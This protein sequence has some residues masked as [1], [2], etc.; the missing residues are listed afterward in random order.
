MHLT[1]CR[2]LTCASPST[3]LPAVLDDSGVSATAQLRLLLVQRFSLAATVS[4]LPAS[5]TPDLGGTPEAAAAAVAAAAAAVAGNAT[6]L[7]QLAV[8]FN[9][10]LAPAL[11]PLQL[12]VTAA[13]TSPAAVG[14]ASVAGAAPETAAVAA[15]GPVRQLIRERRLAQVSAPA[16]EPVGSAPALQLTFALEA[17]SPNPL[18]YAGATPPAVPAAAAAQ[19]QLQSIDAAFADGLQQTAAAACAA[20]AAVLVANPA[21]AAVLQGAGGSFACSPPAQMGS[22]QAI[23]PPVRFDAASWLPGEQWGRCCVQCGG[24]Q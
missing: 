4:L 22:V 9:A 17:L 12:N 21:T 24:R 14:S 1:C 16:S 5:G 11:Q 19:L 8:A 10:S 3:P 15:A 2:R 23:T 13:T 18:L 6:L 7:R 20:L